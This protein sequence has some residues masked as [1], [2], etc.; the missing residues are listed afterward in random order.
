MTTTQEVLDLLPLQKAKPVS[1]PYVYIRTVDMPRGRIK[2]EFDY[3]ELEFERRPSD[4]EFLIAFKLFYEQATGKRSP[5]NVRPMQTG[6]KEMWVPRDDPKIG[7]GLDT[8]KRYFYFV[9][10]IDDAESKEIIDE[11]IIL[12]KAR[13]AQR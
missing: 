13:I 6:W 12:L 2:M 1:P 5:A 4:P 11:F 10:R 3:R 7:V 8:Q 9:F